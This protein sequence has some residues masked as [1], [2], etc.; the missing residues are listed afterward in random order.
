MS[1]YYWRNTT[2]Y[3]QR[4][5]EMVIVAAYVSTIFPRMSTTTGNIGKI[6]GASFFNTWSVVLAVLWSLLATGIQ[7]LWLLLP[8]CTH[9]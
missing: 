8:A 9:C 5:L 1:T 7:R 2:V 6:A 3:W 4:L